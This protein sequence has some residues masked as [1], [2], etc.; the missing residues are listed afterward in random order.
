MHALYNFDFLNTISTQLK[1]CIDSLDETILNQDA[2]QALSNFQDK[3]HSKQGVYLIHYDGLPVYLGKANI[4]SVRLSEHYQKLLGRQKIDP[5]LISYKA[6]LLEKSMGTAANE[7]LLIKLFK[8][9][10]P[11]MWNGRGFGPKD[12][13]RQRDTTEPSDFDREYPINDG[14]EIDFGYTAANLE[15]CLKK[16]KTELPYLFRYKISL[17]AEQSIQIS[18]PAIKVTAREFLQLAVDALGKGWKGVI[19]SYGMIIYKTNNKYEFGEEIF[20]RL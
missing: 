5:R 1:S 8:A 18:L 13:G 12:P 3:N 6:I 9:D 15:E 11:E 20:P 4:I 14:Y 16:V 17:N 19:L 10:Y 2:I 7:A